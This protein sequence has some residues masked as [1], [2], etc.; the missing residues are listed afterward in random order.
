MLAHV[1][2]ITLTYTNMA[3]PIRYFTIR[4]GQESY[5]RDHLRSAAPHAFAKVFGKDAT[6][7]QGARGIVIALDESQVQA[8]ETGKKLTA[9]EL[10][11]FSSREAA[12]ATAEAEAL[13]TEKQDLEA[14][15]QALKEQ[16]ESQDKPVAK[17]T[18]SS[19]GTSSSK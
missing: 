4:E 18:R 8:V 19:N 15:I 9:A 16:L 2:T 14:Q 7:A 17:K 6:L 3:E 12:Q 5:G 10:G 11:V 13:R 1:G